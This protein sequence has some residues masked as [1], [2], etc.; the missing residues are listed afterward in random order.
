MADRML[1]MAAPATARE[2]LALATVLP[3]TQLPRY[4]PPIVKS[5]SDV[6]TLTPNPK[7]FLP[8]PGSIRVERRETA[9]DK[10]G[11][12]GGHYE[13]ESRDRGQ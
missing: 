8:L 10:T 6:V 3:G 11:E 9:P 2:R 1:R 5:G 4:A 7:T 12:H 13:N